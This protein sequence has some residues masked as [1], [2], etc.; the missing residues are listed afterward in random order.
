MKQ[1][2][3]AV[4]FGEGGERAPDIGGALP[5]LWRFGAG[6]GDR[7]P[8]GDR[9]LATR[10]ALKVEANVA[11]DPEQPRPGIV[12]DIVE[13][14]PRDEER[15]GHDVV[16][17]ARLA[18]PRVATDR[19][20]VLLVQAVE[21]FF[22][23]RHRSQFTLRVGGHYHNLSGTARRLQQSAPGAFMWPTTGA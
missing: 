17:K 1:Q 21:P 10:R 6:L 13:T 2:D 19:F 9:L 15:F 20:E 12:R 16:G 8:L 23:A 18:T 3:F 14:P 11:R 22:V 7:Q 4:A 5:W